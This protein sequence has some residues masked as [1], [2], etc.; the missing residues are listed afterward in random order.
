LQGIAIHERLD[1]SI[2]NDVVRF[3]SK[4]TESAT[5]TAAPA[6]PEPE[7]AADPVSGKREWQWLSDGMPKNAT[8]QQGTYDFYRYAV[9]GTCAKFAVAVRRSEVGNVDVDVYVSTTNTKPT[10]DNYAYVGFALR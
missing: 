5:C 8:I 3:F 7:P 10:A 6:Y 1:F 9:N 2:F 4:N